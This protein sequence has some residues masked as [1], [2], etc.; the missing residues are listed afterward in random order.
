MKLIAIIFTLFAFALAKSMILN[1]AEPGA[2]EFPTLDFPDANFDALPTGCGGFTD[3]IEYVGTVL[4][5]LVLGIVFV[6]EVIFALILFVIEVFVL[7]ATVGFTGVEGAP[8]WINALLVLPFVVGIGL[9]F[10]RLV[11]S[12]ASEA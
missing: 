1:T 10:Y 8:T 11:R 12:G 3:C 2:L 7:L 6:V 4:V 9:V 5:N